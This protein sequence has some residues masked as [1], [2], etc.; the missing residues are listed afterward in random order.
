VK[1]VALAIVVAVACLVLTGCDEAN[2]HGGAT[3]SARALQ[4]RLLAPCCWIQT[5][6]VHESELASSLRAE[7]AQRLVRGESGEAIEDDLAA[8]YGERIRA[9]PKGRDPRSTVPVVVGA[10]MLVSLFG[11][12]ILVRRWTKRAADTTVVAN[13]DAPTGKHDEYD[14]RIEDELAQLDDL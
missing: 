7:I 6:D 13:T 11:L 5:L 1:Q 2:P 12:V 14:D 8:R 4:G 10:C 9:V 3:V